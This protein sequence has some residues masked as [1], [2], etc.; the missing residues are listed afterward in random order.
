MADLKLTVDTS[1]LQAAV[2][3]L[4]KMGLEG[5]KIS[6]KTRN[7]NKEFEAYKRQLKATTDGLQ[8]ATAATTALGNAT[9]KASRRIST[10]GVIIQQAGY[11]IG[12]FIVQVQSGTN[13][14]VAFGQQATQVA[15]TLTLLKGPWLLIGS[16]LGIIIPLVTAAGAAFMRTRKEVEETTKAVDVIS[17][18]LSTVDSAVS[19]Q[20]LSLEELTDRY[21]KLAAQ[22][23]DAHLAMANAAAF[24][25]FLKLK[26][27][28]VEATGK[29]NTLMETVQNINKFAAQPLDGR[30]PQIKANILRGMEQGLEETATELGLSVE[31]ARELEKAFTAI[32]EADSL[33][34]QAENLLSVQSILSSMPEEV[35]AQYREILTLIGT[36]G[37]LG[38]E[39]AQVTKAQEEANNASSSAN[40]ENQTALEKRL[41]ALK[42]ERSL[43]RE[44]VA[45]SQK[46]FLLGEDLRGIADERAVSQMTLLRLSGE[47]E[48]LSRDELVN[49]MGQLKKTEHLRLQHERLVKPALK[50][51]EAVEAAEGDAEALA[52]ID[53]NYAILQAAISAGVLSEEMEKALKAGMDMV[54]KAPQVAAAGAR[55]AANMMGREGLPK[56]FGGTGSNTYLLDGNDRDK[57]KKKKQP[58][59]IGALARSLATEAEMLESWR[60]EG[61]L[62]IQDF[63]A[64]ELEL[65]GGHQAAV[66]RLEQEHQNRLNAIRTTEQVS[67]LNGY[68]DLF[69]ALGSLMGTKGKK[70]LQIQ[71]GLSGAA[72]MISSYEAAANAAA[73]APDPISA[74]AAWAGWVAKGVSTVAKIKSIGQSGNASA[75]G[76][77]GSGSIA[78]PSAATEA[79][80][81]RVLVEGI[82][83]ND[84]ISGTQLSEIFDRLYEENEN[85]GLVFQIAT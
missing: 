38:E 35:K 2:N 11:Q 55:M 29:L 40:S 33:Q 41:K 23:R 42:D 63:N 18:S 47:L 79:A 8:R 56:E 76:S 77:G 27:E 14:F 46:E 52:G 57:D 20:K 26:D 58:D 21:G 62:Q 16:A 36:Y 37:A 15:G 34:G 53:I 1:D 19:I 78:T 13:A 71:A 65:L 59:R 9:G 84:L 68:A 30:D 25:S 49:L 61:L 66:E 67:T 32:Q 28:G 45:L 22:V 70:L 17:K 50:F 75:G 43:T 12:D 60:S 44:H 7:L 48:D 5:T 4:E 3:W 72:T 54:E 85:R 83:P 74:A 51:A 31:A 24:E 64:K 6:T 82:G 10:K 80:P 69:G 73:K 39:I 81:Q